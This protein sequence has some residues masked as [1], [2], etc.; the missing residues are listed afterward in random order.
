M[1]RPRSVE[2]RQVAELLLACER[3]Q[4]EALVGSPLVLVTEKLRRPIAAMAGNAGYRSLLTRALTL[5]KKESP[6]LSTLRIERDGSLANFTRPGSEDS[7]A[8][9]DVMLTAHLLGLLVT[10]I[11]ESLTLSLVR[12]ACRSYTFLITDPWRKT[13]DD[14]ARQSNNQ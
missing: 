9:E 11:G 10:F 6:A 8:D 2:N 3:L 4:G 5:A 12:N 14:S 13:E 7:R 1:S